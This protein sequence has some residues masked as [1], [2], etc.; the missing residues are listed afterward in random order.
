MSITVTPIPRLID[1]ATPAFTLG[2]ANAAGSAETAVASDS[3]LLVF[4][5][6]SPASVAASA[7]VGSATTAPRR[8]HVHPGVPGFDSTDP[9]SVAA[10]AS[11]GSAT[12]A[13][14]RDHVHPGIPGAGTVVDSA[15]TR[16]D[17]TGGSAVQ[18]YS[19]LAPTISDAGI[20][21][22]TSGALK[23]PATAI[24]SA[25][26]N[27][28]DDYEE[29]TWTPT[30]RTSGE[31]GSP[32]YGNA[33][34]QYTKIG[35]LVMF[36]LRLEITATTGL[37]GGSGAQIGGLPFASGSASGPYWGSGVGL[38]GALNITAGQT[39]AWR[40]TPNTTVVNLTLWDAATGTTSCTIDEV[41]SNGEF[42]FSG[43]YNT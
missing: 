32:S 20:I 25:D 29:G 43:T 23:F 16:F 34:G 14:H 22:L 21:S 31:T 28:L 30:I 13:P 38:A 3:T 8:D 19:S 42:Q 6:T 12:T 10:T 24:A 41:S 1:L 37:T 33:F 26:A 39:L 15:I 17:G 9:A 4:D 18:G 27:T 2:T 5:T 36:S 7:A 40:I 11:V 35:R